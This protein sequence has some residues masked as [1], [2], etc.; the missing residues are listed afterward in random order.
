MGNIYKDGP[1]IA[2][3]R[4]IPE[5]TFGDV[6][7]P[8][9]ATDRN[10]VIFDGS[11]GKVISDSGLSIDTIMG[12]LQ[13]KGIWDC[14][15]GVYPASTSTGD[16]YVCSVAG[17]ID[18]T[19][20]AIGDWLVYNGST[21]NRIDGGAHPHALTHISGAVDEIDG[22]KLDIDFVPTFY[23]RT[24]TGYSPAITDLTSHL[25]G[26]DLSF[27]AYLNQPV[28]TT[29]SP[30]FSRVTISTTPFNDTDASTKKYVDDYFPVQEDNIYLNAGSSLWNATSSRHGFLPP[31]SSNNAQYLNGQ[32]NWATPTGGQPNSYSLTSFTNQTSVNVLHGWGT[33]PIVQVLQTVT[34]TGVTVVPYSIVHNT[35]NDFTVTFTASTSGSIIASV[36]GPQPQS[37]ITITTDYSVLVSDR[38]I[39]ATVSGIII[40]LPTVSGNVG[41]EFIIDNASSNTI[42]VKGTGVETIEGELI[43]TI[44]S[45]S[46]MNI[47]ARATEWRIY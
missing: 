27:I 6:V 20:Y 33:Y 10:V 29:D 3:S 32:G 11:T 38:I 46:A 43:Q 7:G 16:Y 42:T 44:P 8:A 30:T 37:V 39:I 5:S 9:S 34:S 22:D 21:W 2:I 41:R 28:R 17:T 23:T 14:S 35:L 24:S 1:K 13:Y 18:G 47:F 25:Y 36:G 40:T 4:D 31:L 12:G 26:I 45:N 19:Y 15:G